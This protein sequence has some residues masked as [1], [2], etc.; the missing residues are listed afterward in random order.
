MPHPIRS[1]FVALAAASCL[2]L[3][4]QAQDEPDPSQVLATVDGT[5]ITLGHVIALRAELPPQYNQFPAQ[6]LFEGI[7]DQLIQHTLLMKS[8]E[9]E[10]SFRSQV[11]IEND[12]RAVLAGQVM[13]RIRGVEPTDEEVQ[14]LYDETYPPEADETEYRAAHILVETEEEAAAL[15]A[16]LEGGADFAAL[17]RE[18]STGPSGAV[19]GDLGWFGAGDMVEDFFNAVVDLEQGGI[20]APTQTTFGW[21]VIQLNETR[22]KERPALDVVRTELIEQSRQNALEAFV[23]ELESKSEITRNDT[24]GLDVEVITNYELLGN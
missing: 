21:H 23:G 6:L 5:E 22:S 12:T 17:A 14:A 13:S 18:H 1:L 10:P 9:D 2:A 8:L 3:P 24:S 19:G 15:I 7:L 16:E 20:S 4:A 11:S